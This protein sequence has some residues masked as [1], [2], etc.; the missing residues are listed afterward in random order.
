M[1]AFKEGQKVRL[2][3]PIIEGSIADINYNKLTE[4]L[5]YLLGYSS[6]D[7]DLHQRWFSESD[8]EAVSDE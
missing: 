5:E 6:A 2:V 8:L 7:G 3:A 4:E 1:V